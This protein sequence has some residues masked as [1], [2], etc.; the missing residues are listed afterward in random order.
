MTLT[1]DLSFLSLAPSTPPAGT[2][3]PLPAEM[4]PSLRAVLEEIGCLDWEEMPV[5]TKDDFL[6]DYEDWKEREQLDSQTGEV[7]K[8][9]K[10]CR[11]PQRLHSRTALAGFGSAQRTH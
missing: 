8:E 11:T 6:G 9:G 5:P 7:A 1:T 3:A 2:T 10:E 4:D